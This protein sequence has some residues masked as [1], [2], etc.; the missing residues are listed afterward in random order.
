MIISKV[1]SNCT[2]RYLLVV[3]MPVHSSACQLYKFVN[4]IFVNLCNSYLLTSH[5]CE[6]MTKVMCHFS[7]SSYV[8]LWSDDADHHIASRLLLLLSKP[9]SSSFWSGV[10]VGVCGCMYGAIPLFFSICLNFYHLCCLQSVRF[11]VGSDVN[12]ILQLL[13]GWV[14]GCVGGCVGVRVCEYML[15]G[16]RFTSICVSFDLACDEMCV[17]VTA[18]LKSC[19]LYKNIASK[20][21]SPVCPPTPVPG[22]TVIFIKS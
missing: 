14:W 19:R 8:L 16:I 22:P 10:C 21:K 5:P 11:Q 1:I 15:C 17:D 20:S 13:W 9:W 7:P 12:V 18:N 2:F 3:S 4:M 6:S